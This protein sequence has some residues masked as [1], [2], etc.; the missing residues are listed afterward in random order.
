MAYSDSFPNSFKTDWGMI[1]HIIVILKFE[2]PCSTRRI[3]VFALINRLQ[4]CR[5]YCT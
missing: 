5:K 3:I 1:N 2:L 4:W